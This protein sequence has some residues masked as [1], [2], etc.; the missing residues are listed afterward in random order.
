M[1]NKNLIKAK[2]LFLYYD[3]HYFHAALAKKLNADFYPAPKLRSEKS[4]II[5]GGVGIL[6]SV[7]TIP[8]NYDIY[9]CE[10]TYII[11]AIAK[12][13]GLIKKDAKIINIL[14]SPL[15]YYINTGLIKGIRR[16]FAIYLLKEVNLFVYV[17]KM[18]KDLL[19][20]ILPDANGIV[21]YTYI[22]PKTRKELIAKNKIIPNLK[23]HRLLVIS[24]SDAYYK[25][26]DIVFEAFKIVKRKYPDTK[27]YIV[28]K[29]PDLDKYI[30]CYICILTLDIVLL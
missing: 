10:G 5:I 17:G 7:F 20:N 24:K 11:P 12:K 3:P 28:G 6:K 25:G 14:A 2:V 21:T 29:M 4:N 13:L 22:N 8:K 23:S 19:E 30:D 16:K 27:L 26:I 18:E 15:I 1:Y 9:F